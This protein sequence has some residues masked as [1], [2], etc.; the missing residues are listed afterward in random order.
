MRAVNAKCGVL[1]YQ[2]CEHVLCLRGDIS[3]T[4]AA[5]TWLTKDIFGSSPEGQ[6][7]YVVFRH[8]R[9]VAFHPDGSVMLNSGGHR[10]VTTKQRIWQ[11]SGYVVNAVKGEWWLGEHRFVD[12]ICLDKWG[13]VDWLRTL[14]IKDC[15]IPYY[16]PLI[17]ADWLDDSNRPDE[18]EVLRKA[19][20]GL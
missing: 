18:A 9:I 10:T 12:G 13:Q 4:I 17:A 6:V 14:D 11:F 8:T 16:E 15:P 1:N 5:N 19:V 2:E 20:R 7:Y 3:K